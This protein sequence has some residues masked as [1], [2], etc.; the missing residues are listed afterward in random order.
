MG[1]MKY[2][3]RAQEH[4]GILP[5]RIMIGMSYYSLL[6][7]YHFFNQPPRIY[8]VLGDINVISSLDPQVT[9][10]PRLIRQGPPTCSTPTSV[11][12][13]LCRSLRCAISNIWCSF[14]YLFL[15]WL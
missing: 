5:S 7:I 11:L 9:G 4:S 13:P 8:R 14:G 3:Y 12:S 2:S 15:P 6:C 10:D 1:L